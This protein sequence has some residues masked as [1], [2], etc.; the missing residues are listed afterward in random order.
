MSSLPSSPPQ[1]ARRK[2]RRFSEALP[3]SDPVFSSDDLQD[4]SVEQYDVPRQHKKKYRGAWWLPGSS[5]EGPGTSKLKMRGQFERKMD[6]GIWMG[7]DEVETD[8]QA[9]GVEPADGKPKFSLPNANLAHRGKPVAVGDTRSGLIE[10][11]ELSKEEKWAREVVE[12]ALE[13]C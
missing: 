11:Q 3:S 5:Q 12:K 13:G 8:E 9:T 1:I 2:R 10:D 4:A 6:S 7:S